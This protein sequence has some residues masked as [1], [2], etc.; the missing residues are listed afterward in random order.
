MLSSHH[1][2][3]FLCSKEKGYDI[4]IATSKHFIAYL[5][6]SEA[7]SQHSFI[8]I[9]NNVISEIKGSEQI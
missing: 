8:S 1:H 6:F 3:Y 5:F 7:P 4:A 2:T 9:R